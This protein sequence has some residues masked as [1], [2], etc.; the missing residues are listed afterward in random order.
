MITPMQ[1]QTI[2]NIVSVFETGKI[3]GVDAYSCCT[4]LSD[5]AGISY[6]AHQATA[7]SGSL[8]FVIDEYL[9]LGGLHAQTIRD[10][11]PGLASSLTCRS[12]DR[13]PMYARKLMNALSAAGSDPRM[14]AAQDA[15]F[16]REYWGPASAEAGKLGLVTALGHLILYDTAIQSGPSRIGKLRPMFPAKPPS[17]VFGS[18]ASE[19][20]WLTQF[21]GARE[22]FLTTFTSSDSERQTLVRRTVYR[23]IALETLVIGKAWSLTGPLTVRGVRVA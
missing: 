6:G 2:S 21:L 10:A 8:Q 12:A 18:G 1:R 15:V 13:A 5:G 3:P 23:V 7:K 19:A 20:V 16:D 4:I 14:Q 22:K 11:L 17:A 9:N